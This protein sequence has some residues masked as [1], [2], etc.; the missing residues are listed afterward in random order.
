MP[1]PP[2]R[3]HAVTADTRND[4]SVAGNAELVLTAELVTKL[5]QL[6]VLKFKQLVALRAMEVIVLRIAVI[7]LIDRAA[8]ENEFSEKA[9]IDELA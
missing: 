8:I 5:L 3:T 7:V 6:L 9:R 1:S 2:L 4:Q